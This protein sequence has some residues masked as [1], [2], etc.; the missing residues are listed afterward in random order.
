MAAIE[1]AADW[2]YRVAGAQFGP[3]ESAELRRLA[4]KG[5]VMRGTPI[6]KGADSRWMLARQVSGLFEPV[7]A[8]SV[9]EKKPAGSAAAPVAESRP[10]KAPEEDYGGAKSQ[11]SSSRSS[12][13]DEK[14]NRWNGVAGMREFKAILGDWVGPHL[15]GVWEV[16]QKRSD[17]LLDEGFDELGVPED[18]KA[19]V[20]EA[21]IWLATKRRTGNTVE[22]VE[23]KIAKRHEEQGDITT[24]MVNKLARLLVEERGLK[25]RDEVYG[26]LCQ[27]LAKVKPEITCREVDDL[28][29]GYDQSAPTAQAPTA[30]DRQLF[31]GRGFGEVPC[32][33]P[34]SGRWDTTKAKKSLK[35][36]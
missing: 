2:F 3:V 8:D 33:L 25:T 21:V 31:A 35:S 5:I 27:T 24:E 22:A 10:A 32:L 36:S 13:K 4:D 30:R 34:C 15:G 18:Q 1:P 19:E 12:E 26:A 17:S 16:S 20:K 6:R 23:E 28:F 11:P 14:D 29:S 9:F 7:P